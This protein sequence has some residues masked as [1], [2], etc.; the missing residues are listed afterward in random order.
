MEFISRS[1][2][3]KLF[4]ISVWTLRRWQKK[5]NFPGPIP[6]SS[7]VI[8]YRKPAIEAWL[9]VQAEQHKLVNSK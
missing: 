7:K 3:L 1:D 9:E 4:D 8:M 5:N 6:A 2:V